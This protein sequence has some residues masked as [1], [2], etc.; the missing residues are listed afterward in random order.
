MATK[1]NKAFKL[2]AVNKIQSSLKQ[3]VTLKLN[4]TISAMFHGI[5]NS[6]VAFATDMTREDL[7]DFDTTLRQLLPIAWNKEAEKYVYDVERAVTASSKLGVN[8]NEMRQAYKNGSEIERQGVLEAFVMACED[9]HADNAKAKKKKDLTADEKR[10]SAMTR[11]KSSV[12]AAK[13][14]GATD[15]QILDMLIGMG[16]NVAG[17]TNAL[18]RAA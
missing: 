15:T 17:Y 4:T 3:A 5:I 9:Y 12:K 1:A 10:D 2:I 18:E 11:I 13:E 6:N 16:V 7:A 14:Q 8:M